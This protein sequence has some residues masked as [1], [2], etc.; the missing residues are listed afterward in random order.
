[1][2]YIDGCDDKYGY[3]HINGGDDNHDDDD[4]YDEG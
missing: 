4:D 1:M 2:L 3:G